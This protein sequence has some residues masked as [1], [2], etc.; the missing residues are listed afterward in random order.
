MGVELTGVG[1]GVGLV[2]WQD[3]LGGVRTGRSISAPHHQRLSG[4]NRGGR[5]TGGTLNYLVGSRWV[6]PPPVY[7]PECQSRR[8]WSNAHLYLST[9]RGRAWCC[10]APLSIPVTATQLYV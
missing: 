2:H 3:L 5:E 7:T 6:L 1:W 8:V 10:Q 4:S 9:G